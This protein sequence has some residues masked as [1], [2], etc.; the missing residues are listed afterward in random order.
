M[1]HIW[2]DMTY[3]RPPCSRFW[4]D[5]S[6]C[7]PQD[8]R[9]WIRYRC[10]FLSMC[11]YTHTYSTSTLNPSIVSY[12]VYMYFVNCTAGKRIPLKEYSECVGLQTIMWTNRRN[13]PFSLHYQKGPNKEQI[14]TMPSPTSFLNLTDPYNSLPPGLRG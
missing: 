2:G 13:K 3:Y 5:V 10:L 1:R 6:P 4:R 7:P 8:L 9:P 12:I 11:T 14:L